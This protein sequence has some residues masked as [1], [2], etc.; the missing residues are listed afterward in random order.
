MHLEDV[1]NLDEMKELEYLGSM[2]VEQRCH[3]KSVWNELDRVRRIEANHD[4]NIDKLRGKR[5]DQND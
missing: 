2:V 5:K 4:A 1:S 3:F